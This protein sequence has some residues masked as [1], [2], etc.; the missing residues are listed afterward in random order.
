MNIQRSFATLLVVIFTVVGVQDLVAQKKF[1]QPFEK[2]ENTVVYVD[3][4]DGEVTNKSD[5]TGDAIPSGNLQPV[6]NPISALGQAMFLNNQTPD[7]SNWV[8][9]PHAEALQLQGDFQIEGW[10][11]I[12]Q[13]MHP[14][15]GWWRWAPQ[16]VNKGN[17]YHGDPLQYQVHVYG[18]DHTMRFW[19]Y[20]EPFGDFRKTFSP[21]LLTNTWYH[22]T[23]VQ[24]SS[25]DALALILHKLVEE[26]GEQTAEF[27]TMDVGPA[28]DHIRET[29]MPFFIGQGLKGTGFNGVV[30]E[31]R[32][33]NTIRD[34]AFPPI[35]SSVD[36]ASP[37]NFTAGQSGEINAQVTGLGASVIDQVT[38]HYQPGLEAGWE[39]TTMT[40]AGDGMY[41]GTVPA[42]SEGTMMRYYITSTTES[43]AQSRSPGSGYHGVGFWE[44]ESKVMDLTFE[45]GSGMFEDMSGYQNNIEL[46]GNNYAYSEDVAPALEGESQYAL[47][48][49]TLDPAEAVDTTY[50]RVN[51]PT[52]F[53]NGPAEGYAMELWFRPD[54]IQSEDEGGERD[55]GAILRRGEVRWTTGLYFSDEWSIKQPIPGPDGSRTGSQ[56]LGGTF[57]MP[58]D[59]LIGNWYH[60]I[61]GRTNSYFYAQMRDGNNNLLSED[62]AEFPPLSEG[63]ES[64]MAF[65]EMTIA[66]WQEWIEFRGALD[67]FRFYNYPYGVPPAFVNV[68]APD[69]LTTEEEATIS[70]GIEAPGT[71]VTS[72]TLHYSNDAGATWNDVALSG[73]DGQYTASIPSQSAGTTTLYWMEL[74]TESG[75]DATYPTNF[76]QDSSA[77]SLRWWEEMDRTF[78]F[79]GE[80]ESPED[81]SPYAHEIEVEGDATLS[82]TAKVGEKSAYFP[83]TEGSFMEVAPPTFMTSNNFTVD[84]WFR[85]DSIPPQEDNYLLTKASIEEGI[86]GP[87][88][89][90]FG[91]PGES[92][93]I[94]T[95][96]YTEDDDG[97]IEIEVGDTP[98]EADKWYRV[99][100]EYIN[101]MDTAFV[102]I[103]NEDGSLYK[104]QGGSKEIGVPYKDDGPF[105]I[106]T[107]EDDEEGHHFK[108]WIDDISWYNYS[109]TYDTAKT[110]IED[111]QPA[112]PTQVSLS[113][114]YPNPFNPST[115]INFAVPKTQQVTLTVYDL[116]GRQVKVLRNKTLPTG[117]YTVTWDGTNEYGETVSS[118][119]YFYRLETKKSDVT[120]MR[121]MILLR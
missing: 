47:E 46:L 23:V 20:D 91:D 56:A 9:I 115:Q 64:Y 104:E 10:F 55:G 58:E 89:I 42:Q 27:V 60:F 49:N 86:E 98:Y 61:V 119:M 103:Y 106:G 4:S 107:G 100:Y 7:D 92:L 18:P 114:N 12:S 120:K 67:N 11:S 88:R 6:D 2:D 19:A 112:V 63:D 44:P 84:F 22:F 99:H 76:A 110:A 53:L 33:S 16:I 70:A 118:G 50:I 94:T 26:G 68:E 105:R 109:T 72:A 121:K 66:K 45:G 8:E 73:S 30:D 5:L 32:V 102:R 13:F 117:R 62:I 51:D 34:Y 28:A 96:Y 83:G 41:S 79:S 36:P 35:I 116:L 75:Q 74:Q 65:D 43:G 90:K 57:G 17:A 81:A 24:D 40:A 39:T 52:A 59:S 3:F 71:S 38:L 82:D 14:D 108:G 37:S 69:L 87:L 93:T 95:I 78:Y 15:E 113:Q 97:D 85:A 101:T 111:Q 54:S 48:L 1:M 80:S 77:L 25:A 21:P 29:T 31:I